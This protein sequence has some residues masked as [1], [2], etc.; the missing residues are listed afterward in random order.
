MCGQRLQGRTISTSGSSA[1]MLSAIEHSVI[2]T[3][4]LGWVLRTQLIMCAVEPVKSASAITS[5]GHSGCAMICTD[6]SASRYILSSAPVKR[7]CTSQA[8]FQAMMRTL[9]CDA[10]YLAR[11]WS[12]TKITVSRPRL[13]TTSTAFDEVQQMSTSAFTSAEVLT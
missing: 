1:L 11:Y 7:S 2:I 9:V 4:R 8:P 6:G 12:G 5:G 3:T 13:S 10:T